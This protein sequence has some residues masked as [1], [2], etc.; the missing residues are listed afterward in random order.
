MFYSFFK[1]LSLKFDNL[2]KTHKMLKLL[3]ILLI[4]WHINCG[5]VN[6]TFINGINESIFLIYNFF[7]TNW[8]IKRFFLKKLLS[9]ISFDF[10]WVWY[11]TDY[12]IFA[13]KLHYNFYIRW[14]TLVLSIPGQ[15]KIKG[16]TLCVLNRK[17]LFLLLKV[18][19][20]EKSLLERIFMGLTLYK[21]C[22]LEIAI[23]SSF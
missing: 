2:L 13:L 10:H 5:T 12:I 9:K 18:L 23:S 1:N 8:N 19:I 20:H 22:G 6:K 14:P 4:V 17:F 7:I 15:K 11:Q 21:P 16:G 3:L